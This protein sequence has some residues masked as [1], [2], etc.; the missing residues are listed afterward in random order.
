[1]NLSVVTE[2]R[3]SPPLDARI[4]AAL[5]ACFPADAEVFR[6]TRAWHGSLPEYSVVLEDAERVTAHVGVVKRAIAV[7]P[8][9]LMVAGVQNVCAVPEHRGQGLST[10]L[11]ESAMAEAR[12]RGLD[13]GLLFCVAAMA[14]LYAR[15]GWHDLGERQV[16]RVEQGRELPIPGKNIAMFYPLRI[17]AFPQGLIHLGGND[18]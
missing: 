4:R 12:R 14:P 3:M 2:A 18:W 15:C 16:M 13:C 10:Q 5:C 17:T 1:M 6:H 7:G 8:V 11:L 9:S